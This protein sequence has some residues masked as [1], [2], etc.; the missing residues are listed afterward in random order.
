[1]PSSRQVSGSKTTPPPD[2]ILAGE[3]LADDRS[4]T[5]RRMY[6]LA[7]EL[8]LGH[9]LLGVQKHCHAQFLHPTDVAGAGPKKKALKRH[10]CRVVLRWSTLLKIFT[11]MKEIVREAQGRKETPH[12]MLAFSPDCVPAPTVDG[13]SDLWWL[14][15]TEPVEW[16]PFSMRHGKDLPRISAFEPHTNWQERALRFVV[17]PVAQ[18]N[19]PGAL[20]Q[21]IVKWENLVMASLAAAEGQ[22]IENPMWPPGWEKGHSVEDS[23]CCVWITN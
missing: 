13:G 7:S 2:V 18:G 10:A 20:V 15:N 22:N 5:R 3:V 1:M 12:N 16:K 9:L 6:K 4:E 11:S 23:I 19:S 21:W 8:H 14:K 17:R